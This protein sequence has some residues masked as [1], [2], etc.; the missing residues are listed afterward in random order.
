MG[1]GFEHHGN[2]TPTARPVQRKS[3]RC[4][5]A[6]AKAGRAALA[7]GQA[8]R[9]G[10]P[11]RVAGKEGG[12]LARAL[13]IQQRTGNKTIRPPGFTNVVARSSSRA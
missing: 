1:R 7:G 12:K 11:L 10:A 8:D 9:V 6:A 3:R 5:R 4:R 13:L 2:A